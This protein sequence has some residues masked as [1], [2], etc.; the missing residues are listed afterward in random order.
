ML[1]HVSEIHFFLWLKNIPSSVCITFCLSIHLLVDPWVVSVFCLLC[2][3]LLCVLVYKSL[4]EYL[5]SV[6]WV[7]T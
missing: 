5:F 7:G 6:L 4:N 1:Y 3:M 2:I